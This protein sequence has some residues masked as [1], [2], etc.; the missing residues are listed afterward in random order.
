MNIKGLQ[1][2]TEV[3]LIFIK[4]VKI[5]HAVCNHYLRKNLCLQFLDHCLFV[6]PRLIV[7][8]FAAKHIKGRKTRVPI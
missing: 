1:I 6:K 3:L 4:L 7:A 5:I 8:N 2:D